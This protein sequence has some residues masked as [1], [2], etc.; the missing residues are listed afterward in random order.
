VFPTGG[1][2]S[3]PRIENYLVDGKTMGPDKQGLGWAYQ[4]VPFL[5]QGALQGIVKQA[6]LQAMPVPVYVCPTRRPGPAV[7]ATK[8]VFLIDYAA[9]QP[10]TIGCRGGP[11]CPD[12]PP[13]YNPKDSVPISPANYE[14][15]WPSFW[16]GTN[17][18]GKQQDHFQV[19]DGVIVRSPWRRFDPLLHHGAIGGDFLQGVHGLVTNGRIADG[20]SK[21]FMLGEKYVRADL[22]EGGG[23]SDDRGWTDG[24]DPDTVRSTCFAPYRDSDGFQ[25][26]SLEADDIFGSVK[27]VVYFGSAHA[28][29]FNGIYA[30]GSVHTLNYNVDVVLFNALAT[31][32]GNEVI[33]E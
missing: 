16:G 21:T 12:P 32:A 25:Y 28:G 23:P 27:D 19:Y 14:V 7:I 2:V 33:I 10:C 8:P 22:Y 20:T 5:E 26:Q 31:R 3:S 1:A 11:A 15:N 24:W 9:A 13:R 6:D 29:A 30:D 17:M 18:N 4:I